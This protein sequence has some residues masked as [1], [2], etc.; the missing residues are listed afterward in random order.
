M[1]LIYMSSTVQFARQHLCALVPLNPP[2]SK[3]PT[4][5]SSTFHSVCQVRRFLCNC[6]S[7]HPS[8]LCKTD[9][10]HHLSPYISL[11]INSSLVGFRIF[12]PMSFFVVIFVYVIYLSILSFYV[13]FLYVISYV[14]SCDCVLSPS[15]SLPI[16]QSMN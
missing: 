11:A 8:T 2:I 6:L 5:N 13:I 4:T 10:L 3:Q 7:V 12:K 1:F 16:S 14:Y 15:L 9:R